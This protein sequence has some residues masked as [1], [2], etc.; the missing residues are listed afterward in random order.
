LDFIV[1]AKK[2]GLPS[3]TFMDHWVNYRERFGFPNRRW[4]NN[5]PDEIWV[6]DQYAYK[7]AK[8]FFNSKSIKL[9]KNWYFKEIKDGYRLINNKVKSK[10]DKILLISEPFNS[11]VNYYGDKKNKKTSEFYI[12]DTLID[13]L[14]PSGRP[15]VIRLHPSEEQ[16]KYQTII[17]KYKSKFDV[18]ISSGK[19]PIVDLAQ[20]KYVIGMESAFLVLSALCGKKTFSYIPGNEYRCPL[21][22]K[23]IIKIH[24]LNK[25]ISFIR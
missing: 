24:N 1:A 6:G 12:M 2:Q 18:K 20:A 3:I 22:F 7:L 16:E 19:D 23:N 25:L 4:Q 14:G 9:K 21:P 10:A 17:N 15:V 11:A 8:F 13:K 5:L